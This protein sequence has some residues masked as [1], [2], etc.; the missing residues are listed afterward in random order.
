[1]STSNTFN[2][3]PSLGDFVTNAFAKCG[4]R[5]TELTAQHMQD[6]AFEANLLMGDW[7]GDGILLWQVTSGSFPLTQGTISYPMPNTITFLLDVYITQGGFDRLLY[8]ISRTDYASLA[9]KYVQGYPTSFWYDKLLDPNIYLWPLADSNNTYVLNYY[10]MEHQQDSVL[11][12]G[13]QQA[14]PYEFYSAFASGLA[15]R[16]AYIYAPDR[17]AP[18]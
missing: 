9:Q 18:L 3:N 5:R 12:N 7:A 13:T 4:I 1:M 17:I 16:L 15:S 11:A 14:I 6:A 2:F 10:Y 8:P